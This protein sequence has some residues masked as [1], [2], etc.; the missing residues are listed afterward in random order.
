MGAGSGGARRQSCCATV[1][2]GERLG[3]CLRTPIY[4]GV[5]GGVCGPTRRA[6][7]VTEPR[8]RAPPRPRRQAVEGDRREISPAGPVTHWRCATV[9]AP[10]GGLIGAPARHMSR[11]VAAD[12]PHLHCQTSSTTTPRLPG[13]VR[14]EW[15]GG[16]PSVRPRFVRCSPRKLCNGTHPSAASWTCRTGDDLWS[17][18]LQS[19]S[20]NGGGV[21]LPAGPSSNCQPLCN[22]SGWKGPRN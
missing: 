11:T 6:A 20:G 7:W 15:G 9:G 8:S 12:E 10:S 21:G 22:C 5:G 16:G 13:V 19:V 1:V 18:K 4:G 14:W 3:R 2:H 17:R